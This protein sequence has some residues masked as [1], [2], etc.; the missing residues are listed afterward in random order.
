[1]YYA[2]RQIT[3]Q[4]YCSQPVRIL[5][6]VMPPINRLGVE[7]SPASC[8]LSRV[9]HYRILV[10]ISCHVPRLLLF[11]VLQSFRTYHPANQFSR[12]ALPRLLG[13]AHDVAG[14]GNWGV[15][16]RREIGSNVICREITS[17][18]RCNTLGA[19]KLIRPYLYDA[20]TLSIPYN[21]CHQMSVMK[22]IAKCIVDGQ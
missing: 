1:M 22:G 7:P 14:R 6:C 17:H 9:I 5:V 3:R 19:V 11:A 12:C 10:F 8:L 21:D 20:H 4:P 15:D 2:C 18:G 13:P 16:L